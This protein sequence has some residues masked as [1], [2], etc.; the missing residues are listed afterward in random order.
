MAGLAGWAWLVGW[1]GWAGGLGWLAGLGWV[2]GL[3]WLAGLAWWAGLAGLVVWA[4]WLAGL[5]WVAGL[6]WW[7]GWSGLVAWMVAGVYGSGGMDGGWGKWEYDR[8]RCI[9]MWDPTQGTVYTVELQLRRSAK[10]DVHRV[11]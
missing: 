11:S 5:G 4:G 10:R 7:L 9:F 1:A 8:F 3:G 6:G 2:A